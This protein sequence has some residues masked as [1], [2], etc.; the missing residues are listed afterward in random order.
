MKQ[1]F[2]IS[3]YCFYA[4]FL[5]LMLAF[6]GCAQVEKRGYNFDLSEYKN[7]KIGIS[8]KQEVLELMG[9][10][11]LTSNLEPD[12]EVW[13]YFAENVK[14]FLFFK[15]QILNRQIMVIH[16]TDSGDVQKIENLNLSDQKNLAFNS[17]STP[18]DSKKESIWR[19]IFGN[20]GTVRPY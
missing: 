3:L 20:I 4:L 10:P 19:G 1:K 13:I 16:F 17:N 5:G 8:N 14:K 6:T 12:Q 2:R 7:V 11:S 9:A 18:V 15:P